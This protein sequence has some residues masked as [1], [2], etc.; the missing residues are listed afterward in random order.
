M[1]RKGQD[2]RTK[3]TLAPRFWTIQ[4]KS[5]EFT[6]STSPGPHSRKISYPLVV[7][8][9]DVL[10]FVKIYREAKNIIRDGKILVDSVVRSDPSY[11][12]GLMDVIDIP[13]LKKTYRILP[14][15]GATLTTVEIPESEKNLKICGIK[16]KSTVQG[17][18][19]QYNLHDG[20]S[21]LID[22]G[23]DK[24]GDV[25][26][27]E[28]PSQKILKTAQLKVGSIA[29]VI[30][31]RRTGQVGYVK[32]IKLGTFTRQKIAGLDISGTVTELPANMILI[33]GD[34]KQMLT[35]PIEV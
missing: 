15:K 34:D 29:L 20:R 4:R 14:V 10:K 16:N 21:I 32:E 11:P 3:R 8:V 23:E 30:R 24:P 31:G 2:K 26:L 27:L 22:N 35:L 28:L 12:I 18:K 33:I 25:L 9:R 7:L 6:V 1:G 5:Y 17:G 19:T 13:E